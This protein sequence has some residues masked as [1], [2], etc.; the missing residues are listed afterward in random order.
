MVKLVNRAKMKVASGGAGVLTL[1]Q[2]CDGYQS[3]AAAGVTDQNKLRYTITDGDDWEIGIGTYTASGT[4]LARAVSE[5]SNSGN[6]ITCGS[7]AEIFV[8][9]AAE[10][11]SG[12]V[13]PR[14]ITTPVTELKL[15]NDGTTAVTLTGLAVDEFPVQYSWDGFSGTT[16]YNNDSLPPQLAS[17]PTFSGGTV[18]LIGSGT[19]TNA[20]SFNFRLRASDGVKTATSTTAIDLTFGYSIATASYD[21]KS[22]APSEDTAFGGLT[23]KPDGLT[24]YLIGRGNDK[25]YQYT[26]STAFDV[27]TASYANKSFSVYSQERNATAVQFDATGVYMYVTGYYADTIWQYQ[28]STAFDVSTASYANKSLSVASQSAAPY[29][30]DIKPDGTKMFVADS[31]SKIH[32]YDFSTPFMLNTASHTSS[33]PSLNSSPTPDGLKSVKTAPDGS[34]LFYFDSAAKVHKFTLSTAWD[35]STISGVIE[36]FDASSQIGS[37]VAMTFKPDGFKMYLFDVSPVRIQQFDAA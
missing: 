11:F 35:L 30:I 29:S 25:V 20:G 12:N 27:S 22:F 4:T 21:N 36:T 24:L 7:G 33:T 34:Q 8:T 19:S 32:S 23:F 5:S 6:A 17:A 31:A 13:A 37:A 15:S 18:S 14:W 10:D 9:L 28:L 26:L 16:V 3:F 2:A 1:G